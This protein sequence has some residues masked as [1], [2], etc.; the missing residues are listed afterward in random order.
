MKI[1]HILIALFL[2]MLCAITVCIAPRAD[3]AAPTYAYIYHNLGAGNQMAVGGSIT[4]TFNCNGTTNTL[5]IYNMSTGGNNIGYWQNLGTSYTMTMSTAGKYQAL[6]QT[7]N[8]DGSYT[9]DRIT[10]YVGLPTKASLTLNYDAVPTGTNI[11]FT[12]NSD[13]ASNTL[14]IYKPDGSSTYYQDA[15]SSKTLS[16][17]TPGNYSAL[18]ETWNGQGS[19]K[20]SKIPFIVVDTGGGLSVSLAADNSNTIVHGNVVFTLG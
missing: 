15:G 9:S 3:A 5:W 11:T 20:T 12:M 8:G 16:F 4:F 6:V 10:F 19:K 2:V 14:W 18:L 13:G 7:W 1:K 17:S